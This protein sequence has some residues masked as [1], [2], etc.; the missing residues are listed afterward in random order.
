MFLQTSQQPL[1]LRIRPRPHA[2]AIL[3]NGDLDSP[4]HSDDR[5]HPGLL[6]GCV[7]VETSQWCCEEV[8]LVYILEYIVYCLEQTYV[9][10]GCCGGPPD[11]GTSMIVLQRGVPSIYDLV[12]QC[13]HACVTHMYPAA[14]PIG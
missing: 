4:S 2:S 7:T 13:T 3:E 10:S 9:Y 11:G 12:R 8:V 5:V 6:L 1:V 14:V